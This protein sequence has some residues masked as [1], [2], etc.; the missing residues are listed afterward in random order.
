MTGKV[1]EQWTLPFHKRDE[2]V[3][4]ESHTSD[5]DDNDASVD[6]ELQ[7]DSGTSESEKVATT[8]ISMCVKSK[9]M[10]EMNFWRGN[11]E[12]GSVFRPF[13]CHTSN[14]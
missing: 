8:S 5:T 6:S 13:K 11:S 4:L 14:G 7:H 2:T 1:S 12:S 9:Q 3:A 10:M